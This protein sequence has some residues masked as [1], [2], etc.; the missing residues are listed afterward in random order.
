MRYLESFVNNPHGYFRL[1]V[2]VYMPRTRIK[3]LFINEIAYFHLQKGWGRRRIFEHFEDQAVDDDEYW[4]YPAEETIKK[5][6]RYVKSPE[7]KYRNQMQDFDYLN[8]MGN[9]DDQVP[10]ALARY[11]MDCLGFY[12]KNYRTRPSVGLTKRYAQVAI[13]FPVSSN[14]GTSELNARNIAIMA[15]KFW[16]AD[17]E[18][19][20]TGER[21]STELDEFKLALNAFNDRGQQTLYEVAA[22]MGIE[23]WQMPFSGFAFLTGMPVFRDTYDMYL[24]R[25]KKTK[26]MKKEIEESQNKGGRK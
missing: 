5:Y 14:M 22:D 8:H 7:Y 18:A 12:I 25:K 2:W 20:H 19:A 10:W 21:P 3:N 11:A 1:E 17:L 6:I 24:E 26:E 15:E 13:L 4:G 16:Y 23:E 9:G